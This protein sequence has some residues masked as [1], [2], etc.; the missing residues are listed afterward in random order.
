M[1]PIGSLPPPLAQAPFFPGLDPSI[2][3]LHLLQLL[4]HTGILSMAL[5]A[6]TTT[7][8]EAANTAAA[9][10]QQL[11]EGASMGEAPPCVQPHPVMQGHTAVLTKTVARAAPVQATE[12]ATSLA[13]TRPTGST[14]GMA[15]PRESVSTPTKGNM[16]A[17]VPHGQDGHRAAACLLSPQRRRT[18]SPC[19][20]RSRSRAAGSRSPMRWRSRSRTRSRSPIRRRGRSRSRA[21][22]RSRSRERYRGRSRSRARGRARRTPNSSH[23]DIEDKEISCPF[24]DPHWILQ[25]AITTVLSSQ[26]DGSLDLDTLLER[27][28]EKHADLENSRYDASWL[29][30]YL[31]THDDLANVVE[32][33]AEV[34]F[35]AESLVQ[36]RGRVLAHLASKRFCREATSSL[37]SRFRPP[38]TKPGWAPS[39]M[40]DILGDFVWVSDMAAELRPFQLTAVEAAI[41]GAPRPRAVCRSFESQGGRCPYKDRCN[42]AH[43]VYR[44]R[45]PN[46]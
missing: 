12:E 13:D 22:G 32:G 8:L 35:G 38:A 45:I 27:V 30:R 3:S 5:G 1:P 19:R 16:A 20:S 14:R 2:S 44:L 41:P 6:G 9:A 23:D 25:S 18:A 43:A 24:W 31:E 46:R 28:K 34:A 4:S 39:N 37:L 15:R 42:Y 10:T 26:P 7:A 33:R 36:W 21:R 11:P 29:R 17:Q 40:V